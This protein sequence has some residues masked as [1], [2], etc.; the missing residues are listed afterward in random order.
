MLSQTHITFF[1][2]WNLKGDRV[3]CF[4]A[5]IHSSFMMNEFKLEKDYKRDLKVV[6]LKPVVSG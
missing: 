5:F 2:Q 3:Y 6:I 4:F 1:L